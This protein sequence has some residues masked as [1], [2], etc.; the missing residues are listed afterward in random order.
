MGEGVTPERMCYVVCGHVPYR[1]AGVRDGR[2][3]GFGD[4]GGMGVRRGR[5]ATEVDSHL[6]SW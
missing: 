2:C 5:G 1:S 4:A 3:V 6:I